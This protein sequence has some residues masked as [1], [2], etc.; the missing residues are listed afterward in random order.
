MEGP[1]NWARRERRH[2]PAS[3][4]RCGPRGPRR[5]KARLPGRHRH[6][7]TSRRHP[8]RVRVLEGWQRVESPSCRRRTEGRRVRVVL[9]QRNHRRSCHRPD[10]EKQ[11]ERQERPSHHRRR[12]EA[13]CWAPPELPSRKP[14]GHRSD[15]PGPGPD[16]GC[17]PSQ[18]EAPLVL[19]AD[20]SPGRLRPIGWRPAAER[21]WERQN[22][23]TTPSRSRVRRGPQNRCLRPEPCAERWR[24]GHPGWG[25]GLEVRPNLRLLWLPEPGPREPGR[26]RG[27]LRVWRWVG[28]AGSLRRCRRS[29]GWRAHWECPPPGRRARPRRHPAEKERRWT[30]P[31]A[32]N[33]CSPGS[34]CAPG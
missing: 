7:P 15:R 21:V 13:R 10:L 3:S 28:W 32:T 1:G 26:V 18:F 30:S 27:R 12:P 23:P 14:R 29:S 17:F 19:A 8:R 25:R 5:E 31:C 20:R 4:R 22:F 16:P 24:E 6:R 11:E 9:L 2:P 33:R 34:G